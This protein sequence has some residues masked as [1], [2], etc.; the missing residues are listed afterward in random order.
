MAWNDTIITVSGI[1]MVTEFLN[2]GALE[3]TRAEISE[4]TVDIAA[5]AYQKALLSPVSVP[6]SIIQKE[7]INSGMKLVVQIRNSGA[8]KAYKMRQLGFYARTESMKEELF[9][10]L[11]SKD[12]EEIPSESEYPD[13]LLEFGAKIAVANSEN[14]SVNIDPASV[15]VTEDKLERSLREQTPVYTVSSELQELK[16]EEMLTVGFGK[17]AKAVSELIS[18]LANKNNPHSVTKTQVGLGNVP[19]VATNDQ[20]P[21][22]AAASELSEL[23]SGEKLSA[24]FGKIAKA[25]SELIAHIA[26]KVRHVTADERTAWNSKAA[27]NH[28]HSAA[29]QSADGFMS[30]NDKKKLDGIAA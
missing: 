12:G 28:G 6:T 23:K 21:T 2:G 3:I 19:N 13:F 5:L 7:K 14:I 27:G 24:A 16:S 25:V 8:E 1:A 22:Y 26:D 9:A 30:T 11:Q 4:N 29:S 15:I 17:I 20:T 18:H 10:I